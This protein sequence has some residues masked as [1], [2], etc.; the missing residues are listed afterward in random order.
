MAKLHFTFGTMESQ[1]TGA[2]L[3]TAHNYEKG[4]RRKVL[5]AK[6]SID[7][8]GNMDIVSRTGMHRRV[9]FLVTPGMDVQQEVLSRR[10]LGGRAISALFIDEAQFLEPEQV[11]QL[12]LLAV[13]NR[14]PVL[15][16]GLRTD[17]QTHLFPGSRRLFEIAQVIRDTRTMCANDDAC[18][19]IAHFNA[20]R[21]GGK[22]VRMGAQ[23]AIDETEGV[24]YEALCAAHY[25]DNVG[26]IAAAT[27]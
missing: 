24:S 18:E 16:Y 11:D 20:R 27:P 4:G 8:K 3:M 12:L 26:P 7:T 2:M 22:F 14:V 13:V 25:L 6:P 21:V 1:K 15:T 19:N 5:V 10:K 17:F 9:D 23:V